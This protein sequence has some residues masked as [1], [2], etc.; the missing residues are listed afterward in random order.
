MNRLQLEVA[1]RIARDVHDKRLSASTG[2]R[3]LG[4][5]ANIPDGSAKIVIE[6]YQHLCEGSL[7]KRHLSRV[8]MT[9]FLQS[10][11]G[12]GNADELSRAL[13]ALRLHIRWRE[14]AK[15]S[16]RGNRE[17]LVEQE[18]RLALLLADGVTSVT[19][20]EA[21]FL[22]DVERSS[23]M[24]VDTRRK[25][26]AIAPVLPPKVARL[27]YVYERNADV[28]AEVLLQAK[29]V[30]SRCHQPGPFL[31]KSN[32]EPYLEVHHKIMLSAG[33]EDTVENAEALCANC[34]RHR[35]FGET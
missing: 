3:E 18:S 7:F 14:A 22:V 24:D 6:V 29:G 35:H 4:S 27:V 30:C 15:V 32:G 23:A 1:L 20:I 2:R 9:Y 12:N 16:Q 5:A 19:A 31:R 28:V 10:F 33:G 11:G 21:Q 8:D 26:L 13:D 25:R 17:I 34:H